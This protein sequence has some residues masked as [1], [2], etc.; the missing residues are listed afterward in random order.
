M[1][2][3]LLKDTRESLWQR[4]ENGDPPDSLKT[5]LIK[6]NVLLEKVSNMLASFGPLADGSQERNKCLLTLF[7]VKKHTWDRGKR[8]LERLATR[9]QVEEN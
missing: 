8:L 6:T 4:F 3:D 5:S 7:M 1:E 9:C 2:Y